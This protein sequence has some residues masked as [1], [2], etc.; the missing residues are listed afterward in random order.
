M[1][2]IRDSSTGRMLSLEP[3][4]VIGRAPTCTLRLEPRYV[5]AQHA[6]LRWTGQHWDLRDLGSS[7][8]TFLDGSRVKPAEEYALRKGSRIA[9]GNIQAEWELVD[10][11]P[12]RVM[13]V[14]LDG[15]ELVI[16]D[17]DLLAL[18]SAEDPR[19]TIYRGVG[20]G[21]VLEQQDES[22]VPLANQQVFQCAG[23]SWRFC[24]EENMC[25]TTRFALSPIE[26]RVRYLHLTFSVS[27]DE[28]HVD[29][30]MHCA[31]RSIEMG[32]RA[33]NY[34]L[35]TLAR[36]RVRDSRDGLPDTTCGWIDQEDLS[37][38]P[39][40]APPQLNVDVFRIRRQYAD[41]GVVDAA[42][43]IE[44]RPGQLRIGTDQVTINRR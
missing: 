1:G 30:S 22:V 28:E 8:G 10:D 38:D 16:M 34:L 39:R 2:T 9:F 41:K 17:G 18:P 43:I 37:R 33:H 3:E 14:P 35:L 24:C 12:P 20:G 15:G 44:R 26:M 42:G 32:E 40:M 21:W 13:A 7:N 29:I 23:R 4:H 25:A 11:S 31:G 19:A 6:L 27:L 5:S 36:R